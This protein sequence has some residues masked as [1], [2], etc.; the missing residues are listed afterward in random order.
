MTG[1]LSSGYFYSHANVKKTSGL[2]F[3]ICYPKLRVEVA[4]FIHSKV[5]LFT[6]ERYDLAHVILLVCTLPDP[7]PTLPL[8]PNPLDGHDGRNMG[9]TMGTL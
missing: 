9:G 4:V 2:P 3:L 6:E 8:T 1:A 5:W 7:H